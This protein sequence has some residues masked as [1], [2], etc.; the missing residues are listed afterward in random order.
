MSIS[1]R[2]RVASVLLS[3]TTLVWLSGVSMLVPVANGQTDLQ[4]QVNALLAQIAQLQA[5]LGSLQGGG[6]ASYSFT[7]DLTL[8]STGSDVMQL[9]QF[10][11]SH[12]AMVASSGAG[13]PGSESTYFGARTKAA[14]ASYQAA[15]GIS[16]AAGY[17]GPKT[18]AQIATVATPAPVPGGVGGTTPP[19]AGCVSTGE[20]SMVVTLAS[21]PAANPNA[22]T[23]MNV[24]VYGIDVKA[25]NSDVIVDRVNL[26]LAVTNGSTTYKPSS[27]ITA[28]TAWDGSTKL[29][30]VPVNDTSLNTDSS[31]VYS[32]SVGGINFRVPKDMKKT[33]TFSVDTVGQ[34]DNN[35][36]VA[37][38]EYGSNSMRA[39]DCVNLSIYDASLNTSANGRTHTFKAGGASTL[40]LSVASDNQLAHNIYIDGSSGAT[41]VEMLRFVANAQTADAT[42]LTLA[43]SS[44]FTSVEPS[45]YKLYD[46][47]GTLL[48][49]AATS[50]AAGNVVFT[51]VNAN[52]PVNTY[53]TFVIKADVVATGNGS[54][55]SV[56]MPAAGASLFR[57]GDGTTAA[58]TVSSAV[59]GNDVHAYREVALIQFVSGSATKN[60]QQLSSTG[61]VV[62]SS[63]V[64]GTL[65]FKITAK[66]GTLTLPT[67]SMFVIDVV[68]GSASTI[69]TIAG[70]SGSVTNDKTVNVADGDTVTV[71][72]SARQVS[73]VSGITGTSGMFVHYVLS[74][75]K[76]SVGGTTNVNQ[77]W[78]LS[79]FKT[80]DVFLP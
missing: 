8:G 76:W 68:S 60:A 45:V 73:S 29:V 21:T 18:R 57:K 61:S 80:P 31:Y 69:T 5:Q 53:K 2:N 56:A 38:Q 67:N 25:V 77:T 58:P 14:L 65:T 30:T 23:G 6:S 27:F 1:S 13:A 44:T 43:V 22:Y 72:L 35:R 39:H 11:N 16:P 24:P 20:G 15:H 50:S 51:N 12:G 71:A 3:A 78:G 40:S 47:N 63:S 10:L 42:L 52:V 74:N 26:Q 75:V 70:G 64:D 34:I 17:F 7:R 33:L 55:A 62:V 79:L 41:D 36:T 28:I 9:Q 66:G 37:I 48:A 46:A 32:V 59:S 54:V 49:S 19:P 4:A